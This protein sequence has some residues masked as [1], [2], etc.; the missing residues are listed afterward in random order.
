[1]TLGVWL[2]F[3]AT[4][5]VLAMVVLLLAGCLRFL[6]GLQDRIEQSIPHVTAMELGET[7]IHFRLPALHSDRVVDSESFVSAGH[8]TLL[9]VL[10]TTCGDCEAVARQIAELTRRPG[11]IPALGWSIVLAWYGPRLEVLEKAEFVPQAA[12]GLELL[13]DEN[14]HL[15]RDF[16]VG[17]LPIGIALDARG[18]V[19]AQSA[20]PGPNWLYRTLGVPA[21]Q[22]SLA[23]A[24]IATLESKG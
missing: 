22:E 12:P 4:W 23:P 14:G 5:L 15:A 16:R 8:T 17:S 9:L 6:N 10:T 19:T 21:P 20:N 13:L 3:G 1:M 24:W 18:R 11:G 7:V 2:A